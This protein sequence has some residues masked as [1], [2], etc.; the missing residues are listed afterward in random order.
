MNPNFQIP[1]SQQQVSGPYSEPEQS[2]PR[3]PIIFLKMHF[4]I[5]LPPTP[6]FQ[7]VSV[8]SGFPTKSP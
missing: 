5:I 1:W 2:N 8:P 4:N 3:T 7:A 6:V